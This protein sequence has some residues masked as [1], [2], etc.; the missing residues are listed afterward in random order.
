M[1]VPHTYNCYGNVLKPSGTAV[2]Q[3]PAAALPCCGTPPPPPNSKFGMAFTPRG[4]L[5][6]LV[7]FAGFTEDYELNPQT[8]QPNCSDFNSAPWPQTDATHQLPGTAIPQN[9]ADFGYTSQNQFSPTATDLTVSNYF[10]QISKTTTSPLRVTFDYFP[11]RINVSRSAAP[12]GSLMGYGDAVFNKIEQDFPNF[13]WSPW[14]KRLND[15]NFLTDNG[16]LGRDYKVDYV[17]I[18]WRTS[19]CS[20]A[21]L[22]PHTGIA[23][24]PGHTFPATA[25][26]PAY[27]ITAG[28]MQTG[29][30]IE[31]GAFVREIAHTVYAAPHMWGVNRGTTGPYWSQT[32]GWG[33]MPN[34]Q[35][36][37][38]PNAWE[39][40]YLG[41]TELRAGASQVST[42]IQDASSLTATG[43]VYT[44]RDYL[45]TGDV[46]RIRLPN[47][48]QYLWLE[49]RA[50]NSPFD[51]SD[52]TVGGDGLAFRPP[53][54]GLVGMVEDLNGSRQNQSRFYSLP[55][56]GM[57]V[58]SAQ[59][60][61]DYTHSATYGTYNNHLWGNGMFDLYGP[62]GPTSMPVPNP[63]GTHSQIS[64][65]RF[66]LTGDG[67]INYD[68]ASGN[69]D[70]TIGNESL[71]DWVEQ[72]Q[73]TDGGL[74]PDIGARLVGFRYGLD[75]NPVIIPHQT[76]DV[77]NERLSQIPLSGLSVEIMGYDAPSGD[78]TLWVRYD[79]TRIRQS[80][81]W[82]GDL[83]TY[84]VAN[85]YNG[86]E[87]YVDSYATLTLNRSA[88]AQRAHP[89]PGQD[90]VND[91]R[92]TVSTGTRLVT[93][94]AGHLLLEGA[95]TT[96]YVEDNA[97]VQVGSGGSLYAGPGTT[98]SVQNRSDLQDNGQLVLKVGSK[99]IIR[100]TGQV[101]LGTQRPALFPTPLPNPSTTG[102][103]AIAWPADAAPADAAGFRYELQDLQ[104]QVLRRGQ[105][106]ARPTE[107]PGVTAGLYLLVTTSPTGERKTQR[108]E[109]R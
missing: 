95:G 81:R 105:C 4:N 85:A 109:V 103:V 107:L 66:D 26:N 76:Y 79:D 19:T 23:G 71:W 39:R 62:N 50:K 29:L 88:T 102:T 55:T 9:L 36:F 68:P 86:A 30:E 44:L 90:F 101:I 10:Y 72:G 56:N 14:D 13:D 93:A 65:M 1:P 16:A 64:T 54:R 73:F 108:V 15:P 47:T 35:T 67:V 28:H 34:V 21:F 70:V 3:A 82:T 98:I 87:V 38:S 17:V 51:Q 25:T 45:S 40:W 32:F 77:S 49:N 31:K 7:I 11:Q 58:V 104:G 2:P 18:C 78:L 20:S 27:T 75:T 37:Q 100:S 59:G 46:M 8:G 57:R 83:K 89:G 69:G 92:L 12:A 41:W 94:A 52:Y 74:G 61:F 42:D 5:L 84:P 91:T 60:N 48:S 6:I 43:G 24:V 33:M 106:Q 96:L 22:P 80:T 99:L 97:S 63:T 53:P